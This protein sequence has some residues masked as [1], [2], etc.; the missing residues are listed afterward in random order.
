MAL[1]KLS[2]RLFPPKKQGTKYTAVGSL[3]LTIAEAAA[4]AEWLLAQPGQHDDYLNEDVIELV[5]FKYAN[6]SKAGKQY[7]TVQLMEPMNRDQQPA[8]DF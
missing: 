5:A 1:P 6:T 2:I 3:T 8:D 7:E 4:L